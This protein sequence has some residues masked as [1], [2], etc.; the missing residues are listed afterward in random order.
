VYLLAVTGKQRKPAK[1]NSTAL[2]LQL[3]HWFLLFLVTRSAC[4]TAC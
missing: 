4:D 3:K 2:V 1:Y